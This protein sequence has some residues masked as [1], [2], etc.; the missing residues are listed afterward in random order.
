MLEATPASPRSTPESPIVWA[1]QSFAHL[2]LDRCCVPAAVVGVRLKDN[3]DP[4]SFVRSALEDLTDLGAAPEVG[5]IHAL[6][7]SG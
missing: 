2:G 5:A 1:V 3:T 7:P 6:R 4:L